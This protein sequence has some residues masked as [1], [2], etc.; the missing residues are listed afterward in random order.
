MTDADQHIDL[1]SA[2]VEE[3]QTSHGFGE[4]TAEKIIT[5]RTLTGTLSTQLLSSVLGFPT[6]TLQNHLHSGKIE[7][8]P[9]D[10]NRTTDGNLQLPKPSK[11]PRDHNMDNIIDNYYSL[12][13]SEKKESEN[14]RHLLKNAECDTRRYRENEM[15]LL[16]E[17][18][19]MRAALDMHVKERQEGARRSPAFD[20]TEPKSDGADEAEFRRSGMENED[21][22]ELGLAKQKIQ[23]LMSGHPTDG[24]HRGSTFKSRHQDVAQKIHPKPSHHTTSFKEDVPPR[25]LA[26]KYHEPRMQSSTHAPSQTKDTA[27]SSSWRAN[28]EASQERKTE[29]RKQS[30]VREVNSSSSQSNEDSSSIPSETED[31]ISSSDQEDR[32]RKHIKGHRKNKDRPRRR[33]PPAPKLPIFN[34]NSEEWRPF[35]FQFKEMATM[36]QWSKRTRLERLLGCLSGKAVSFVEKLRKDKR[37]DYGQL[38]KSLEKRYGL[39][40]PPST[41]RTQIQSAAQGDRESLDEWADRI[42]GLTLDG[43]PGAP[44][45]MVESLAVEQ[46]F[47]GC[48]DNKAA[49]AVS[50]G[51][52]KSTSIAKALKYTKQ[53]MYSQKLLMGKMYSAR[54]VSFGEATVVP[55]PEGKQGPGAEWRQAL[56]EMG[57]Q[58]ASDLER[59]LEV[60]LLEKLR[61]LVNPRARSSS[62]RSPSPGQIRCFNCQE[63]GHISRDCAKPKRYRDSRS[64]SPVGGRCFQCN[65][66]GHMKRECPKRVERSLSPKATGLGPR[67]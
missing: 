17:G 47:R 4:K 34:G 54:Q 28:W 3:I 15:L 38:L 22:E 37:R 49:L 21:N 59:N 30:S 13:L 51:R 56:K 67:V 11:E 41:I 8:L 20:S 12:I 63:L 43:F 36:Q 65:E 10:K 53:Y 32:G 42:Y 5:I 44:D 7:T 29:P 58:I 31:P 48:R 24:I 52:E 64:P 40:E 35:V 55:S 39:L 19:Q 26:A 33:S 46:F 1:M 25:S 57:A 27:R 6:T 50:Q 66:F 23:S 60:R 9:G 61:P 2:S 16:R 18:D 62:Y 14:L 45:D